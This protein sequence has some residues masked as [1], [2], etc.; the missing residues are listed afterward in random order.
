[1]IAV[2]VDFTKSSQVKQNFITSK[3]EITNMVAQKQND[4]TYNTTFQSEHH[5]FN[6]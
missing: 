2:I 6:N 1:M 5:P 4:I 3:M